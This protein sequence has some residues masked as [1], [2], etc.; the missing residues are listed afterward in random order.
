M[1]SAQDEQEVSGE[2]VVDTCNLDIPS[3][4]DMSLS[5]YL[6]AISKCMLEAPNRIPPEAYEQIVRQH[7]STDFKVTAGR[8]ETNLIASN[9]EEHMRNLRA[10]L[11]ANPDYHIEVQNT[12]VQ[13][14]DRIGR[15]IVFCTTKVSGL[16]AAEG[17]RQSVNQI[18]VRRRKD[19]HWIAYEL[20]SLR[21][22]G[23]LTF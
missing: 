9:L 17:V 22:P 6:Q 14:D 7:C 23:H 10:F 12:T 5:D 13:L 1:A 15:A 8:P 4:K 16:F 2:R 11:T 20:S 19:G 21:G 3:M 18:R